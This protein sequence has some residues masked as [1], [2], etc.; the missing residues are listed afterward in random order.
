MVDVIQ[1]VG[2]ILLKMADLQHVKKTLTTLE[3]ALAIR[4]LQVE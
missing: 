2:K 3:A 4:E 1:G